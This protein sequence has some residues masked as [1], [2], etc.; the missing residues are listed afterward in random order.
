MIAYVTLYTTFLFTEEITIDTVVIDEGIESASS[1]SFIR[2]SNFSDC[3]D[4]A[5]TVTGDSFGLVMDYESIVSSVCTVRILNQVTFLSIIL[6][7]ALNNPNIE[8]TLRL[9]D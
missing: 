5:I 7:L 1:K 8:I 9:R 4:C 2:I 3:L 6:Q